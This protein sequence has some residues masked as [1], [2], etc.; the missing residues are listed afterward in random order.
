MPAALHKIATDS[1]YNSRRALALVANQRFD[2]LL[3]D[4][5]LPGDLNGKQ[6]ADQALAIQPDLEVIYMSGYTRNAIVHQGRLDEDLL[7]LQKPFNQNQLWQ[8]LDQVVVK[9]RQQ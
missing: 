7:L 3:S 2:I 1:V 4:L 8:M 6:L 5:V 9:L